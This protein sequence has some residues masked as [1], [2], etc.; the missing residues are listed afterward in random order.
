MEAIDEGDDTIGKIKSSKVLK[1]ASLKSEKAV[2]GIDRKCR[3]ASLV[4]MSSKVKPSA[5]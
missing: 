5:P 3:F 1:N 4:I 2:L